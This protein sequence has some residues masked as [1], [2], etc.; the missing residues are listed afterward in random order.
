MSKGKTKSGFSYTISDNLGDDIELL[1]NL[2]RL[3]KGE[4]VVLPDVLKKILGEKQKE[5]LYEH[6][7]TEDGRVPITAVSEELAEIFAA[8]GDKAKKS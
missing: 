7:R 6:L 2:T 5:K 3:D 1:E 8:Q 4:V